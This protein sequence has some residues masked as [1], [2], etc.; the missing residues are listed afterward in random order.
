RTLARALAKAAAGPGIRGSGLRPKPAAA[1]DNGS[2]AGYHPGPAQHAPAGSGPAATAQA[3][4]SADV[5]CGAA[6]YNAGFA[7]AIHIG[8]NPLPAPRATAPA[9][10]GYNGPG[11]SQGQQPAPG[12]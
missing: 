2:I 7:S 3:L 10:S 8:Q 5:G 6:L 9:D 1:A 11:H 4:A 12:H